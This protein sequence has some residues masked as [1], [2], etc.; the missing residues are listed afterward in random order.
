MPLLLIISLGFAIRLSLVLAG[1]YKGPILKTFEPYGPN[2]PIFFPVPQLLL[3]ASLM[4]I[5]G[6]ALLRATIPFT[7]SFGPLGLILLVGAG[8][9]GYHKE[10]FMPIWKSLPAFPKWYARFLEDT[11][12]GERRRIAYMWL[13]LPWRTR[14]LYNA[15]DHLFFIWAE[16][17]I[18][19]TVT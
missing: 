2:D 9:T 3:W 19:A 6:G 8:L 1:L 7:L 11:S 18:V 10:R 13:R 16:Y 14:L 12:R 15:N 17:V 4:V 5:S